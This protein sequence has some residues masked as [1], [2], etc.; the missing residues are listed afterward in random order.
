MKQMDRVLVCGDRNWNN[1]LVVHAIL[2]GFG[3]D[4]VVIHGNCRG[5]DHAA[6]EAAEQL[7]YEVKSYQAQWHKFGVSA[8]PIRNRQMLKEGKPTLVMA[9]HEDLDKSQGTKD[10]IKI[11]LKAGVEVY[12]YDG[13]ELHNLSGKAALPNG[14]KDSS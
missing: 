13:H 5:A 4:T 12:H 11:A 1:H 2:E 6:K 14:S 8:G 3:E 9:F 10:M 7:G